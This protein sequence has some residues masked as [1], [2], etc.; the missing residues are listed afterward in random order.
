M[1]FRR[2]L[3]LS[4]VVASLGMS[5]RLPHKPWAQAS[6]VSSQ[7]PAARLFQTRMSLS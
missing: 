4:F 5:Q 3:M 1:I 6:R 2:A 7:I